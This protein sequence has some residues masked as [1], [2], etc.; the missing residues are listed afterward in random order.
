MADFE[1]SMINSYSYEY[2]KAKL[3]GCIHNLSQ[4]TQIQNSGFLKRY[5]DVENLHYKFIAYVTVNKV[6]DGKLLNTQYLT[7]SDKLLSP[8]LKYIEETLIGPMEI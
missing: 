4:L 1:K 6:I 7:D 3:I 2:P 5:T 8:I